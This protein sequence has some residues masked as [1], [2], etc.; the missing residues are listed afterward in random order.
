MQNLN[1][2]THGSSDQPSKQARLR[3]LPASPTLHPTDDP[4][5]QHV[6]AS[7]IVT[8]IVLAVRSIE[9]Q[10]QADTTMEEAA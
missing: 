7:P 1:Q 4:T 10:R 2:P 6:A 8:A 3:A 9:R 5:P